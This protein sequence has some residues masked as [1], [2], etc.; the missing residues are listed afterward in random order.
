MRKISGKIGYDHNPI[1]EIKFLENDKIT[2]VGRFEYKYP[3]QRPT[4]RYTEKEQYHIDI[5]N[6]KLVE[7]GH[8]EMTVEETDFYID[9]TGSRW[10]NIP[11]LTVDNIQRLSGFEVKKTIIPVD[12]EQETETV[13]SD[14]ISEITELLE[15]A[16]FAEFPEIRNELIRLTEEFNAIK[17]VRHF[18]VETVFGNLLQISCDGK[19]LSKEILS[20]YSPEQQF[21]IDKANKAASDSGLSNLTYPE[22][23]WMLSYRDD[24]IENTETLQ[25]LAG[26]KVDT[27]IKYFDDFH[28]ETE[29]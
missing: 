13:E 14:P 15:N 11:E 12:D 20:G 18:T 19:V 1:I 27:Q 10:V 22:I 9:P 2:E 3:E 28:K 25:K 16:D 26:F 23:E 21:K 6:T 8:P 24:A 5:I 29:K 7:N 17:K 4:P